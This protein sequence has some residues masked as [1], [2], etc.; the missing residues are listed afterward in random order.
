MNKTP[1]T[2]DQIDAELKATLA[3][4]KADMPI[5]DVPINYNMIT[6]M[7]T[8]ASIPKRYIGKPNDIMTT[9]L[10][11]REMGIAPLEALN[12]IYIVNGKPSASGKLLAAM[13][14][15]AGHI[16]ICNPSVDGAV[17]RSW[18]KIGT[19]YMQMPDVAFTR[20]DAERAHL[21]E[22]DTY[23]EYPAAMM[24][25][26]ALTLAARLH[27]PDVVSAIGY[28]PDEVG[29][30]DPDLIAAEAELVEILDAEVIIDAP[31]AFDAS[32]E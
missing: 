24:S 26:R 3:K 12:E 15:R 13:I 23:K 27:F 17:V 25:W 4:T 5:G 14:W 2:T 9:M 7:A 18:R 19:T 21:M 16:I 6:T 22:K 30:E 32:Y 31:A 8:T 29:L 1:K 28:T 10:M 20:E 11:G